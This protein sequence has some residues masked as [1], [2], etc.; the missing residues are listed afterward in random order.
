MCRSRFH[1]VCYILPE[2]E[3]L[4]I[5]NLTLIVAIYV[6]FRFVEIAQKAVQSRQWLVPVLASVALLATVV[7]TYGTIRQGMSIAPIASLE[8]D[9]GMPDTINM[10]GPQF[11]ETSRLTIRVVSTVP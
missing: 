9:T 8:R 11:H 5:P 7:L 3:S 2:G 4:V 6:C 10:T 1:L